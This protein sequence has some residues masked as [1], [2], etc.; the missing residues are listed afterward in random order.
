MSV[1][2]PSESATSAEAVEVLM[3]RLPASKVGRLLSS[4][5]TGPGD[6]LKLREELFKR[7]V[8]TARRSDAVFAFPRGQI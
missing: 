4:W 7:P 8:P 3:E 1:T 5:Q 6:Y 2:V